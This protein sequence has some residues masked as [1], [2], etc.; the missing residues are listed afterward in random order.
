MSDPLSI[1]LEKKLFLETELA[2]T[3]DAS[4]KF[5]LRKQIQDCDQEIHRLQY[6]IKL[7]KHDHTPNNDINKTS[8]SLIFICY[9]HKDNE[10]QEPAK[11]WLDRLNEYLEALAL[12]DY[13][14]ICSDKDIEI[15]KN[16]YEQIQS[17]LMRAEATVLLVSQ[18]FL[19][20]TY[21]KNNRL[22][23][24]LKK[25]ADAGKIVIPIIV[26][27]CLFNEIKFK[28]PDPVNGYRELPLSIFP[29]INSPDKPLNSME[30][31]EQDKVLNSVAHRLSKII[32]DKNNSNPLPEQ[33]RDFK[34]DI[35]RKLN[36]AY[37]LREDRVCQGLDTKEIDECIINLRRQQRIGPLLKPDELLAGGR[38]RLLEEIGE[39]GFA[40]IWKA[41]DKYRRTLVAIKVLHNH[42]A[43]NQNIMERFRRGAK[44][45]ATL[46]HPN[47]VIVYEDVKEDSGFYYYVM[48]YIKH[49]DFRQKILEK[50]FTREQIIN[51]ILQAGEALHYAHENGLLHRDV[52]PANIL[53]TDN[54]SARL[55]D[56]DLVYAVDTTGGTTGAMG[57][58]IYT[59]PEVMQSAK[60]ASV[61][62]DVYS[63]AMTM[64]F[65]LY[66]E[67]IPLIYLFGRLDSL[68]SGLNCGIGIKKI[69]RKA[70]AL[71][72][73]LRFASIKD[74]CL[75]LQKENILFSNSNPNHYISKIKPLK[76]DLELFKFETVIID[77]NGNIKNL[78]TSS[79]Y[80]FRENLENGIV[81]DMVQIPEGKFLM[82]SP[83]DEGYD[84]EK[85][86]HEVTIP[87]FYIGKYPI[88]QAQWQVIMGN[89]PSQFKGDNLPVESILWEDAVE[90]CWRLSQKTG[91]EYSLPSEAQWEYACRA[92]TIT[93]FAFG[94]SITP[95]VVNYDGNYPYAQTPK[96]LYRGTTIPVGSLKIA[97]R[98]G[99]YDMHGNIW[100]WCQDRWHNNYNGA[101]DD[102]T[103]WEKSDSE[104]HVLRGGA[105]DYSSYNSRSAL[106]DY[107]R[108]DDHRYLIGLRVAIGTSE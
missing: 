106:R 89:N 21:I 94:D 26:R 70:V 62:S 55:T 97:N 30:E 18:Y 4:Q 8:S 58:I 39:G 40:T 51:L 32:R 1:W 98:F 88:T 47:I 45:M 34:D 42:C 86:Q 93:P 7:K 101:P 103:V 23:I 28:Y 29:A 27:H 83:K 50:Q 87:P 66:G 100:E 43:R 44:R 52:K 95:E 74:F 65:G 20:S 80:Y 15:E 85:P 64:V 9:A 22:P 78:L 6:Q 3:S 72:A 90:F 24:L 17:A 96:G 37:K 77:A 25:A 99:L 41:F 46:R 91:K 102:G 79:T 92:G 57:T 81:L 105:W 68:V 63:L 82:G 69:L 76:I 36:E 104:S 56:F 71:E 5:T 67:D 75:E 48:E 73:A 38:F 12:Q 84:N 33:Y 60:T 13:I 10:S 54:G 14:F 16:Q 2:K 11:R 108:Y 61:Q 31:S 53:I 35:S 49:G 19:A 107:G 59:A